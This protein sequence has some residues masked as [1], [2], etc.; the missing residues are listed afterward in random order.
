MFTYRFIARADKQN[1]VRLR[2]TNNRVAAYL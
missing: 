2:L 1:D